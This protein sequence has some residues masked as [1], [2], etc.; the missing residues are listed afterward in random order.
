MP[1]IV[2][3]PVLHIGP[4]GKRRMRQVPYIFSSH[5]GAVVKLSHHELYCAV[6]ASELADIEA[7][8]E[9]AYSDSLAVCG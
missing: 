6:I 8:E 3:R 7:D 5:V 9:A 2:Y 1:S 4:T